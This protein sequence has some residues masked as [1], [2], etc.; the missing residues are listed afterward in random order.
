MTGWT[1]R[2]RGLSG[3]LVLLLGACGLPDPWSERPAPEAAPAA[4][5]ESWLSTGKGLLEAGES[6]LALDAFERSLLAEGPSAAAMTGAGIAAE[7]QGLLTMAQRYFARA[8][9]LAPHS[10]VANTNLGMVLYRLKR[11]Y[12][13]RHA[14]QTA[15]ALSSGRND[16]ALRN[17]RLVEEAIAEAEAARR[18]S[19]PATN[20]EVRR[21]GTYQFELVDLKPRAGVPETRDPAAGI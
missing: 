3:L 20:M 21:L 9:D 7:R 6:D 15:F 18:H 19:D 16:L 17:L 8:R 13:A 5:V 10:E 12:P 11:Y 1:R 14:F 4:E 2:G